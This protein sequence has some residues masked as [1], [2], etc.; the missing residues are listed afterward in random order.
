[1]MKL[2]KAMALFMTAVSLAV[3]FSG[4]SLVK[5][6]EAGKGSGGGGSGGSSLIIPEYDE[7]TAATKDYYVVGGKKYEK[8]SD[9]KIQLVQDQSFF[10][11]INMLGVH[12]DYTG[13]QVMGRL[14]YDGE[15]LSA[16]EIDPWEMTQ[17]YASPSIVNLTTGALNGTHTTEGGYD[18]YRNTAKTIRINR[19]KNEIYMQLDTKNTEEP[20][21]GSM[22]PHALIEKTFTYTPKFKD[23]KSLTGSVTFCIEDFYDYG[24][25][26]GG[27]AAQMSWWFFFSSPY[28]TVVDGKE[29]ALGCF[30]GFPFFDCRPDVYGISPSEK[31]DYV[32]WEANTRDGI[33][34]MARSR[35]DATIANNTNVGTHYTVS[36]DLKE[37]FPAAL[38][39]LSNKYSDFSGKTLDEFFLTGFNLG[40]EMPNGTYRSGVSFK[41]ISL[42]AELI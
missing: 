40:W 3:C 20:K 15:A 26:S 5:K 12:P 17:W 21:N 24:S 14:D 35:F 8:I 6:S 27:Q 28:T 10:T 4:C 29:K 33:V 30:F 19:D 42:V 41:D 37:H 38:S 31:A 32:G 2:K 22:W 18:Y 34:K 7:P 23:L 36:F 11:G 16:T 39:L 1:M 13:R 25:A 9:K